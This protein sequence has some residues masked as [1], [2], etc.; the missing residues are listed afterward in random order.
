MLDGSNPA[1]LRNLAD[2][3]LNCGLEGPP[4]LARTTVQSTRRRTILPQRQGRTMQF[5]NLVHKRGHISFDML[6]VRID[7][8]LMCA[9]QH[10][11]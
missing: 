4:T 3:W 7:N 2:E 9:P 11:A 1:S 10:Y 6:T 5:P 8:G